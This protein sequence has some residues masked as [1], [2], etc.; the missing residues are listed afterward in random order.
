[1]CRGYYVRCIEKRGLKINL[2]YGTSSMA[3]ATA[4]AVSIYAGRRGIGPGVRTVSGAREGE[5]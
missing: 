2:Q 5:S 3:P 4:R 1:M